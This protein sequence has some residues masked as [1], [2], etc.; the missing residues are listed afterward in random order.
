MSSLPQPNSVSGVKAVPKFLRDP[1]ALESISSALYGISSYV[2][3]SLPNTL[4]KVTSNS[5]SSNDLQ[6]SINYYPDYS[7]H[8]FSGDIDSQLH[9]TSDGGGGGHFEKKKYTIIY[10]AF[11]EIVSKNSASLTGQINK[12]VL[13]LGYHDGFQIWNVSSPENVRELI[14]L[15]DDEKYGKVTC[16]KIISNP[17]NTSKDIRD[18]YADVRPLVGIV[19]V[20]TPSRENCQDSFTKPK[21]VLKFVSLKTHQIVKTLDFENEGNIVGVNCNDR[22]IVVSLINPARLQVISPLTLAPLFPSPL[23][24]VAIHPSTRFPVFALGPR[25]LAYATTSNP[26]EINGKKD[27]FTMG[28][29]ED[30]VGPTGKYQE[31]AKGVAKEV[32]NGVKLLSDYGFQTLS[33]YFANSSPSSSVVKSQSTMPIN[34]KNHTGGISPGSRG[35]FTPQLSPSNGYYYNSIAGSVASNSSG[36]SF[37]YEKENGAVGAIIIRDLGTSCSVQKKHSPIIAHFAPHTHHVGYMSFSPS[38]TFLFSTSVQGHQFHIFEILGKRRQGIRNKRLKHVYK[39]SRGYTDA[40]V[41]EGGVDWSG[42]SR[43]CAVASGRGTVHV[44]AIN[45]YGGPAHVPSHIK[46][47]VNNVDESYNTTTQSPVVRIKPRTP[48]PSDSTDISSQVS[49]IHPNSL[50]H[51]SFSPPENNASVVNDQSRRPSQL[52]Y[53]RICVKFLPSWS[54]SSKSGLNSSNGPLVPDLHAKRQAKRR[55]S[56]TTTEGI[57]S[58]GGGGGG[59]GGSSSSSNNLGVN[60]RRRTQSWSQNSIRGTVNTSGN[61]CLDVEQDFKQ[62]DIGYQDIWSFHPTGILTLHRIW[63]E[64]VVIGE[65]SSRQ[66]ETNNLISIAGTP[67][68][69]SAAAVA[70]VGR[71]LVGS[72]AG[73]VGG[74]TGSVK[75]E[76][77][78]LDMVTNYED[79]AEWQLIRGNSWNE[80]KTVIESPKENGD[81]ENLV[82]RD[83]NHN[84]LANAEIETHTSSKNSLPPPLWATPQFTFQTFMTGYK[85]AL[86]NGTVPRSKKI[87]IR[88]DVVERVELVEEEEKG[89]NGWINNRGTT[90][91]RNN[92]KNSKAVLVPAGKAIGKGIGDMSANL[93]TA[94]ST[95]LGFSPSSPTLSAISTKSKDRISNISNGFTN[96][97]LQ[98]ITSD[99]AITPLSFEDAYH[100]HIANNISTASAPSLPQSSLSSSYSSSIVSRSPKNNQNKTS[101]PTFSP[102]SSSTVTTTTTTTND[103]SFVQPSLPCTRSISLSSLTSE[104]TYCDEIDFNKSEAHGTDDISEDGNFFFSPDGD[105]EVELPSDSVVELL[106]GGNDF[107]KQ[108]Y[109]NFS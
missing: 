63:I 35:S 86:I 97:H 94:M 83:G 84:W 89:I 56:P 62:D 59:G 20:P 68:A 93:S 18:K 81:K 76:V 106:R 5:S 29:S 105:N 91:D 57:S 52:H 11:D 101:I 66:E 90:K 87:E 13:L 30:V 19:C 38:G 69:G 92:S 33:A 103:N 26:P 54:N 100:I 46:G 27:G 60:N 8:Q 73:M 17:R 77:G 95:S 3:Y 21:S 82:K 79:V 31:V 102:L 9:P 6:P 67:L 25:L 75:K 16:I 109:A 65:Q 43:W 4:R 41:G 72:A 47:W 55:S 23:Q 1:S 58:G 48:L 37:D 32:V 44:F 36:D 98:S 53:H 80:V 2:A 71:V 74:I 15:R 39:L 12:S 96:G 88:R 51:Y 99:T 61:D 70:N 107:T 10:S 104:N 85:D 34:I 49:N 45:P 28:D 50:E 22:A 40:I 42:D 64:G 14:S 24:D 108:D 78:S 7:Q